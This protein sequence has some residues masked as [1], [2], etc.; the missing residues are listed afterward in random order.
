MLD[1]LTIDMFAARL[2]E[3]F[4]LQVEPER[5]LELELVQV[6]PL[7]VRTARGP[8]VPRAREP[9]SIVFRGPTSAVAQQRIYPLEHD[10]MG[11]HELFIVPIGPGQGGMLYEAIFS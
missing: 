3:T 1:K 9:F 10:T 8:E 2:G 7:K 5:V 11:T 6:T 4:R